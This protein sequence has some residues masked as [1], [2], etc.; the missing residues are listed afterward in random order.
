MLTCSPHNCTGD[1]TLDLALRID[2]TVLRVRPDRWRGNPAR[3]NVIKQSLFDL[4][5]SLDA[6]EAVFPII[7]AQRQEY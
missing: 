2:H 7:E 1:P 5:G 4:L 6:V 3:E